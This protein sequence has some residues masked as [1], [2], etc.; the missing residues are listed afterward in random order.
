M[1]NKGSKEG[2]NAVCTQ[3]HKFLKRTPK[4]FLL[5]VVRS[6]LLISFPLT[7]KV[8]F[9]IELEITWRANIVL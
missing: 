7:N 2:V 8:A 9:G 4:N 6:V 3:K 1:L 5:N